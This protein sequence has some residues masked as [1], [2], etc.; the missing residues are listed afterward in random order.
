MY[1][2]QREDAA[3]KLATL[4][5]KAQPVI[6][7][8]LVNAAKYDPASTVRACCVRSLVQTKSDRLD[9]L[10]AIE[11]LKSDKDEMVRKEADEA[12]LALKPAPKADNGIRQTGYVAPR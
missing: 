9:V 1:P 6:L 7:D 10:A 2:S 8:A 3:E 5:W 4:D 11:S 12:L